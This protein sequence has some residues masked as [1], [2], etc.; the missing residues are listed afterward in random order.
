ME[1]GAVMRPFFV[2]FAGPEHKHPL[3]DNRKREIWL[4]WL[5]IAA[6]F[7]VM[8]VHSAEP[9]YYGAEGTEILTRTDSIWVSL[10]ASFA[11]ACV[12]LF[13]VASS[14]L[15]FPLHYSSG[16]FVRRRAGRVLIPFV[17]WLCVYAGF[18]GDSAQNFKDLLVNFNYIAGHLWFVYMLIGLYMIMPLLS[19]WAEKV[20]KKELLVYLGIWGFTTF[21]PFIRQ[22]AAGAPTTY[23]YGT[24]GVPMQAMFPL[25]GECSWNP[26]G[27]FHYLS[28]FVG[29][30]LLGLY[31]RKFVGELSWKKTLAIGLPVWLAGFVICFFGFISRVMATTGGVFPFAGDVAIGAEWETPWF[32]NT[33]GVALMTIGWVLF[34]KKINAPGRFYEKVVLRVS[35]ASYGMY[36]C[37]MVILSQMIGVFKNALGTGLD[38][39]LGVM[40]TPVE[41]ILIAV[42]SYVCVAT[43]SILVQRIPKVGKWII[44]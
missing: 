14:Y 27:T 29:Y 24:G 26:Y 20:G 1:T 37:H 25:W 43:V 15:Q 5:R 11:R 33:P 40:T 28:G 41:I 8:L 6:C 3:M 30:L 34:F 38:G 36:L 17:I 10:F 13:V 31:F 21:I 42:C 19:P 23:I 22:A 12:P 32:N 16:E 35:K 2:I 7:F 39:R 9:F 18:Y 4:D 44:G